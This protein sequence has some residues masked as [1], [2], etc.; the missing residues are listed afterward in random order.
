MAMAAKAA[1]LAK[2]GKKFSKAVVESL[3]DIHKM[4]QDCDTK[5]AALGY[6]ED[7]E[8]DADGK[9]DDKV[10][11]ADKVAK[12]AKQSDDLSK[13]LS[14][15]ETLTKRVKEL[16]A[17]PAPPKGVLNA[18]S[19]VAKT[20]DHSNPDSNDAALMKQAEEIAKLPPE[21]QTRLLIKAIHA[22]PVATR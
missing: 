15:V 22:G 1:G 13:A 20:D 19:V 5:L 12:A 17:Q 9:E 11:E 3:G 4:V 8:E 21:E 6:K 7:D 14:Q 10:E 18:N 2:G 16:E